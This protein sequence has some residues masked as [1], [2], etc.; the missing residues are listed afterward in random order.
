MIINDISFTDYIYDSLRI[1]TLVCAWTK[2]KSFA[3]TEN[4]IRLYDYYL[5]FPSTMLGNDE[6]RNIDEYYSFFH[7]Q[8]D[9]VK[10]RKILYFLIS[11]GLITREYRDDVCYQITDLGSSLLN[12]LS[13]NK[14]IICWTN[15]S[16]SIAKTIGKKSDSEIDREIKNKIN[17]YNR[18]L[19]V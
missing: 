19:E 11:K 13:N 7:W 10:Y 15:Q 18:I 16:S 17:I 3:L 14:V 1:L 5:K 6:N 2:S 4:K 12:S 9:I 8:P